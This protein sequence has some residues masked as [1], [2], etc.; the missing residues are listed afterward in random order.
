MG[1]KEIYTEE[2]SLKLDL[3]GGERLVLHDHGAARGQDH[4]VQL[5]LPL[6]RLLVPFPSHLGVMGGDQRDLRGDQERS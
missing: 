6:V 5:L 3:A 4:D 2:G 1:V